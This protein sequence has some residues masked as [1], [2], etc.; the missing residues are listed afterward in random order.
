MNSSIKK[1][2]KIIFCSDNLLFNQHKI[3][4]IGQATHCQ[5][6]NKLT[7]KTIRKMKMKKIT[8][9]IITE[10][11]WNYKSGWTMSQT[12]INWTQRVMTVR[13]LLADSIIRWQTGSWEPC[14]DFFIGSIT[15]WT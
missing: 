5:S 2:I 15:F 11:D 1:Q 6:Y 8:I 7:E 10:L 12:K 9:K 14:K 4:G 3:L 13:Y